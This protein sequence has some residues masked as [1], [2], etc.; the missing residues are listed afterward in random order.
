MAYTQTFSP[1]STSSSKPTY[2]ASLAENQAQYKNI[3][4]GYQNQANQV[5]AGFGHTNAGY[6]ALAGQV[7]GLGLAQQQQQNIGY[8]QQRANLGQQFASSGL[9]SAQYLGAASQNVANQAMQGQVALDDATQKN[10][11]GIKGQQ[12]GYQ[13]GV[14]SELSGIYGAQNQAMAASGNVSTSQ[15]GGAGYSNTTG[16]YSGGGGGSG[17]GPAMGNG[18]GGFLIKPMA[19]SGLTG[20]YYV[21]GGGYGA[22]P[23]QNYDFGGGGSSAEDYGAFE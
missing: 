10:L 11:M 22:Q 23:T 14:Q 16:D 15:S 13:A 19:P 12:L 21:G 20:G 4:A 7:S 2:L 5:V 18:D 3:M 1:L 6:N 8:S 17:G 9:G